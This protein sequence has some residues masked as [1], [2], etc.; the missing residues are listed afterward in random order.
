MGYAE[1]IIIKPYY[2]KVNSFTNIQNKLILRILNLRSELSY[3]R[4]SFISNELNSRLNS[5]SGCTAYLILG[6]GSEIYIDY[7]KAKILHYK[8]RIF[9]FLD[10]FIYGTTGY[11]FCHLS[12]LLVS[13]SDYCCNSYAF[14]GLMYLTVSFITSARHI[15][16]LE[17]NN[18]TLNYESK[19]LQEKHINSSSLSRKG[20]TICIAYSCCII[21]SSISF[22]IES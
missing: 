12:H 2:I 4:S 11:A 8:F 6:G 21:G 15:S 16:T 3:C 5:L 19:K 20:L 18:T 7:R 10:G 17:E 22:Y 9:S 13:A 1:R 14:R